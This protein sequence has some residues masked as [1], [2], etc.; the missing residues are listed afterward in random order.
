MQLQR[1]VAGYYKRKM[2]KGRSAFARA[3][4]F[5]FLRLFF[6]AALYLV[7]MF[8]LRVIWLSVFLAGVLTVSLSLML[9]IYKRF[10]FNRYMQAEMEKLKKAV[11]YTHLTLPTIYSV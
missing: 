7:F 6:F 5:L 4:D 8:A 3:A 10:R 11:S 2:Y 1:Q 9:A